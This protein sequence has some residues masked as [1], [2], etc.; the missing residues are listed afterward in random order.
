MNKKT[1]TKKHASQNQE[2]RAAVWKFRKRA[3][4][5]IYRAVLEETEYG[6]MLAEALDT[7]R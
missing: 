3:A 7:D 4:E 5:E 2:T 6:T 1:T